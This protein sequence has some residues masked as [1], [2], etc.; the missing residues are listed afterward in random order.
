MK[1]V[2]LIL[3]H[4]KSQ[5]RKR[6]WNLCRRLLE[7]VTIVTKQGKYTLP[8]KI[9]DPIS[10]SLFIKREYELNL[11]SEAMSFIRNLKSFTKGKGTV[12]DVGANN[13]IISIGMLK[14]GELDRAIS[15]EPEPGNFSILKHN[16]KQNNLSDV[17]TCLNY[18]ASDSISN[19]QFEL[20]ENNYG[21]HRVHISSHSQNQ[22]ELFNEAKRQII[23]VKANTLDNI[24]EELDEKYS[25]DISVIWIDVQGYEGYVFSGAKRLFA[26]GIPVVSEIWPY[27]IT[28]SGMTIEEFFNIVSKIWSF[29]WVKRNKKFVKYPVSMLHTYF[30]E[31]GLGKEHGNVIFT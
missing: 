9:N 24:I 21:D 20:S 8:L 22:K 3:E 13:G 18:A 28:R 10:R 19:L 15:I 30:D 6:L 27:G 31:L 29:F 2:F 17:I 26:K 25:K 4:F 7:T 11:I 23:N 5:Y 12:L 14:A 16:V 1:L